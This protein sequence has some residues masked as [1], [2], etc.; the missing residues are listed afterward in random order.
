MNSIN[1]KAAGVEKSSGKPRFTEKKFIITFIFVT[2]LFMLWGIAITMGDILNRHF[3]NVLNVS[4]AQSGLVQFS[5]FGAYAV[6][7]IPAGLF[8]KRFGYKN[9]VLLGL[10]LYAFGA[11][12]FVP[13]ANAESFLFFRVALFILAC[14]LATLETV[15]HPF[16]A[17]L[18]DQRTSD[19]RINF[20]Q[21][22]NGV[23]AV[24]GPLIGGY[25]ILRGGQDQSND[26]D[27]VKLLYTVIGSVIFLI[28][29]FFYFV[30]VPSLQDPHI[31]IE[32]EKDAYAVP[33]DLPDIKTSKKLFQHKHFAWAAAAQFFNV[34][35]QGGTWAFFINYGV[36]KMHLANDIAAY[37]FS[38][39]MVMMMTG[40]F[41]GTFLMRY[42]A[43]HKLLAGFA[44]GSIT[45]CLVIAQSF[46]WP[47]FIAL[48]ALNFFFSIMFPTIF[49]L[50]IKDMGRH[51]QQA[52][53]FIVMGV[54]G[55]AL[56][57]P[58]MGRIA[59]KDIAAAY[60]LPILCY[61]VIFLFGFRYMKLKGKTGHSV[62]GQKMKKVSM[63]RENTY[64]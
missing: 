35:A 6:M 60:Y 19:Q 44:L 41:I 39:S 38:L 56:F 63:D 10:L 21:S 17:S 8:M 11:F 15:A 61:F 18:G 25:F 40:R 51:T 49:S 50:G 9:G 36:E 31:P 55:G 29:I 14:G 3:Q 52:S 13:A 48:I 33:G 7:A 23:G 53:S 64:S 37:Y 54:V 45:M 26:L 42:I 62:A 5:L 2:S 28:A 27:S 46:G 22:F 24:L 16:I 20:A 1:G 47:S 34:A 30:K 57:P 58:L 59:D 43:P 12:L 4:K 32:A